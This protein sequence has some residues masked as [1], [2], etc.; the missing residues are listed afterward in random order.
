[1]YARNHRGSLVNNF[2]MAGVFLTGKYKMYGVPQEAN[3]ILVEIGVLVFCLMAFLR[4]HN[5]YREILETKFRDSEIRGYIFSIC[6][7]KVMYLVPWLLLLFWPLQGQFFYDDLL[8]Y[9]FIICVVATYGSSSAP[10]PFLLFFDIAIPMGVAGLVVY[11]NWNVQETRY[12]GPAVLFFCFYV[13]SIGRKMLASTLQ[14]IES[15]K[16][17]GLNARRADDANR[18]K[19][20]FLALMSHEIRTPM[21]GIFGM[22]DFLKDTPLNAEQKDFVGTISDCSKTLLNT[23]NDV[24]DFSKVESGKLDISAVNF[25]LHNMLTNSGRV[26]RQTAED[27][28]LKLNLAIADNVP[29]RMRGDPHRLQQVIVNLLNN[30][31]KFTERGEVT[32]RATCS[33]GKQ[34][35]LRIEVQ[36]TGIGISKDNIAKLFSAFS[37]ADNSIARRYGGSGLGLSIAKKLVELMGGKIGVTSEEGKGSIFFVELPYLAPVAGE[38]DADA[39]HTGPDSPPQ[40]ILVVEDNAVS[41]RIVVKMLTQKGHTVTAVGTGD[42]ALNAVQQNDFN[43][44]FM[45]VNMP[46]RNGL[47]TTRAIHALGG[48]LE[49]LPVIGLTANIMEDFVRKCY[50]AGMVAHVPKPF[51]PKSLYDAVAL[52]SGSGKGETAKAPQEQKK[53][54]R[55][56]LTMLRDGMGLDYVQ[57]MVASNLKETAR[58][59]DIVDTEMQKGKLDK[60][61]DAA[62]DLK[63]ITGLIGM[64]EASALAAE[65]EA[66]GLKNESK[67]LDG[68]IE[69]LIDAL[70]RESREAERIARTMPEK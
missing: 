66:D 33:D 20:S 29:K 14:L 46:G 11:L 23:L 62:H 44:V 3:S 54:M 21:T 4:Q 27:K 16:Q 18:A 13:F 2:L 51:S 8:G 56:T 15:K 22:V 7:T 40:N 61:S 49:K 42:D 63:S 28:G 17:A 36:D 10:V 45:D 53:S 68:L 50:D 57:G 48:K 64:H 31:V 58:L 35:S 9:I 32:L 12:A 67:R 30:G 55:A 47:D 69:H 38:P 34:P 65:V 52:V 41:Q 24:L 70:E 59:M 5:I 6:F 1:M 37:Q 39:E 43:M 60:M 19:S 25:D 26:M